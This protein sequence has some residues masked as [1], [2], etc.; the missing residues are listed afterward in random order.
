[1]HVLTSDAVFTFSLH[2]QRL[3]ID[4]PVPYEASARNAT[5]RLAE[6]LLVRS[7][8]RKGQTVMNKITFLKDTELILSEST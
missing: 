8:K 4:T 1:M 3:H 5:V 2:L 7:E 6:A